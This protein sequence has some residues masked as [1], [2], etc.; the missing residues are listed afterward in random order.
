MHPKKR[1]WQVLFVNTLYLKV[2][3]INFLYRKAHKYSIGDISIMPIDTV[4]ILGYNSNQ[5]RKRLGGYKL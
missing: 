2:K 3:S 5:L 4:G 1:Q